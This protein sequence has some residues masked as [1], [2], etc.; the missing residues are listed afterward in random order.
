M[1]ESYPASHEQPIRIARI[2]DR[3]NIGG[4]AKH[5]I[6][7][8]SE[9]N[10]DEFETTLIT[11]TVS[12]GEGD[13]SYFARDSGVTPITIKEMSRELGPR[14]L[15]VVA[16]LVAQLWKL[17]PQIIH[18]HKSKAGATG[19]VAAFIYKWM[20]PSSLWLRPRRCYVVHTFHGHVF[21][22]YFGRAKSQMFIGAEKALA[23]L[24]TDR[25]VVISEQQREEICERFGV[26][27]KDQ[28]AVI[29]LGIDLE[30]AEGKRVSL[31]EE[32]GIAPDE[33]V[34][35]SVG[36]LCE[37]K[38]Y[39]LLLE[40]TARLAQNAAGS[41]RLRVVIVGDGHLRK[42]IESL[43]G[44]LGIS[45]RV[46]FTGFRGDAASLYSDFDFVAL[47]SFNEGTP[48]SLIE[49]MN[50]RL[51]V[52]ATEVGGVVD[53]MGARRSTPDGFTIWAHGVTAPSRQVESFARAMR[54]LIERPELRA[55]MGE[56]G[57]AF[58]QSRLSKQRL[59]SDIKHLY[60]GLLGIQAAP[61]PIAEAIVPT[62]KNQGG[63]NACGF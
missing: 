39:A 51:A 33:I 19:R 52:A 26:G 44:E 54:L 18:T 28:F 49:A 15:V 42:Q 56:R 46:I 60:R 40:A 12:E 9:L 34:V 48:L 36:R 47:T 50:N 5:V 16:R 10:S 27:R 53:L 11:G 62:L 41:S 31:R 22:G 43:A 25:I 35:G 4:P 61:S 2:I 7:L 21:H 1:K 20:T 30:E 29:P 37:V 23:R 13:M 59:V 17:K 3:L 45:D 57:Y 8:T 55:E 14:D 6:W 24:C 58:V 38:N 63:Q 32:F